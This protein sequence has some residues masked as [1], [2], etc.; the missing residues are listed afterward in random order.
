MLRTN[1]EFARPENR[2]SKLHQ[3]TNNIEQEK[4]KY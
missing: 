4:S 3:K 2:N 1:E